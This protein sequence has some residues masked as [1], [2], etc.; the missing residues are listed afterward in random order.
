MQVQRKRP[1]SESARVLVVF[2]T[3][4]QITVICIFWY[5]WK[6]AATTLNVGTDGVISLHSLLLFQI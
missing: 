5:K 3:V 6:R 2:F 4:I 1:Q